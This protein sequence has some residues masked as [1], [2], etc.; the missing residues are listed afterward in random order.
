MFFEPLSAPLEDTVTTIPG[1]MI[2]AF[3]QGDEIMKATT[4][5]SGSD[6][7]FHTCTGASRAPTAPVANASQVSSNS[8]QISIRF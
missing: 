2:I 8:V 1:E 4:F 7:A 3:Q 5:I 6:A